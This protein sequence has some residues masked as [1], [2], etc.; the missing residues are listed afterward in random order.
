MNLVNNDIKYSPQ[1]D[2][3]DIRIATVQDTVMV[4]VQDYGI[5]IPQQHLDQIFARFYRAHDANSNEF[6]GLGMGLYICHEIVNRH[7]RDLTVECPEGKVS[8][9]NVS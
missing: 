8:T 5:G 3:V 1:A 6:P 7:A 4:S 9:M 2:K